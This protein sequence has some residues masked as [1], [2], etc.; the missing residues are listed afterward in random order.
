MKAIWNNVVIADSDETFVVEGN[1]YFPVSAIKAE[2]FFETS[3]T[4]NCGWKGLAN[5]FSIHVNGEENPNAAWIYKTPYKAA[6]NIANHVAF[7]RGIK[8]VS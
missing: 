3:H 8:V 6:E 1:H 7:W 4:S 5:Y 2:Y